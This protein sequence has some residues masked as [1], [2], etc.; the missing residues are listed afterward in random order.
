G[1]EV[2]VLAG[3]DGGVFTSSDV[4]QTTTQAEKVTWIEHNRGLTTH[5]MYSVA[6]G[7][8]ATGNPFVLFGGLQDNGT[9]Y[10]VHPEH[11]SVFNE[12]VGP[13]GI[14]ATV[15]VATSGT[16]SFASGQGF[17]VYCLPQNSDCATAPGWLDIGFLPGDP[18]PDARPLPA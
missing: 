13:D 9:R 10:R 3:T 7:D 2:R 12:V 8:P 6:S 11:P 15:H 18:E 5:L 17:R 4:F 16:T 1:S 14:G